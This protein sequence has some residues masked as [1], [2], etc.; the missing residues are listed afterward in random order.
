MGV[1]SAFRAALG[2]C[3]QVR[4]RPARVLFPYPGRVEIPG[5][6]DAEIRSPASGVI[7]DYGRTA[8]TGAEFIGSSVAILGIIAFL[9]LVIRMGMFPGA[10][11]LFFGL[12]IV[13][14]VV[15]IIR[16]LK[17]GG[18]TITEKALVIHQFLHRPVIIPKET[19]TGIQVQ[20]NKPPVP[21]WLLAALNLLVVPGSSA[22]ILL[23]EYL[24]YAA[25]GIT[26]MTFFIHAAFY[27]GLALLF[28]AG[29]Y[30]A[31][32]RSAYPEILVI[33]TSTGRLAGI[34]GASP[35]EMGTILE[36]RA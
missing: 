16:D 7:V 19:I 6:P 3:P 22:I 23:L 11:F 5:V 34:Y 9:Y 12:M 18:I 31:R 10:G 20:E 13:L 35:E 25:G 27:T 30:H 24:Q 14:A 1:V 36:K 8:F 33:T 2:W 21:L 4:H 29:F 17:Q 32:V 15:T 28:L 26:A